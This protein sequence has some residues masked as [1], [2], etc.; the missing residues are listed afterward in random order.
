MSTKTEGEPGSAQAEKGIV[1]VDG[2]NA[3]ALSLTP[4]AAG[5]M[6][7]RM[8]HAAEEASTHPEAKEKAPPPVKSDD[9]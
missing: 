4:K 9:A 8:I 6:G 3:V 1:I 7:R 5:E 2:P